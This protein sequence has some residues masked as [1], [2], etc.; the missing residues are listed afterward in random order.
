MFLKRGKMTEKDKLINFICQNF[1]VEKDEIDFSS[2]LVDQGIIDSFGLLEIS[3]FLKDEM[4]VDTE[5]D[6]MNGENFGSLEKIL[7]FANKK[8]RT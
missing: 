2:S 6:E 1:L 5:Q 4:G 7:N 8:I 3:A